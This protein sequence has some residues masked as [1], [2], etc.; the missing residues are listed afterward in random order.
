MEI[1]I[2]TNDGLTIAPD[3]EH[4]ASFRYLTAVNGEVRNDSIRPAGN[5]D[6]QA[7][8]PVP[9]GGDPLYH[10]TVITRDL[11]PETETLL[12][13]NDF[14]IFR[15]NDTLIINALLHYLNKNTLAESNY[16]CCP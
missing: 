16:C 1:L 13:K 3:Y 11:L 12:E 5:G 15:T 7:F 4:A 14:E 2:P 8:S 6:M 10:R 9:A